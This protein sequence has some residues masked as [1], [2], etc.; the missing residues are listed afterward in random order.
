MALWYL[1]A[2]RDP[3]RP[4]QSAARRYGSGKGEQAATVGARTAD[5]GGE[6]MPERVRAG[7][8]EHPLV[9]DARDGDSA[10]VAVLGEAHLVAIP[11]L[12]LK[13]RIVGAGH[14]NAAFEHAEPGAVRSAEEPGGLALSPPTSPGGG[15]NVSSTSQHPAR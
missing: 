12:K 7:D 13:G 8:F 15:E 14:A 2:S 9:G 10:V 4:R 5:A 3:G 1:S 11:E 6:G